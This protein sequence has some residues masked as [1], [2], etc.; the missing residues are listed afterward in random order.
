MTRHDRRP[1]HGGIGSVF[2]ELNESRAARTQLRSNKA[3]AT[4]LARAGQALLSGLLICGRCGLRMVAQYNNNGANPRYA[5]VRMAC[6]YGEPICQSLKAAL[7]DALVVRLVLEALESAALEASLLAVGE[8]EREREALEGQWQRRLERA[9]YQAERMHRQFDATEPENRLV[10]RTLERQW[11][12]ALAEQARLEADHE[13]FR[14][15]QPRALMPAEIAA[16][17]LAMRYHRSTATRNAPSQSS[18]WLPGSLTR[19]W[20]R[21]VW[22]RASSAILPGDCISAF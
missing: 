3:A 13:R 9:G 2:W 7:L 5:C 21:T 18:A 14:R 20:K 12:Q 15:D 11:E 22:H 16:R 17:R 6:D 1:R 4:G 19:F 8:V 10:A